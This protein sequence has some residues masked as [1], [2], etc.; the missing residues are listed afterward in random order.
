MTSYKI[1]H[2]AL[3]KIGPLVLYAQ[4]KL[5][6]CLSGHYNSQLLVH[7]SLIKCKNHATDYTSIDCM[8]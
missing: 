3:D 7:V 8:S 5:S 2:R 4:D 1:I 6:V